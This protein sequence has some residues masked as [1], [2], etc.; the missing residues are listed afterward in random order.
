MEKCVTKEG[1]EKEIMTANSRERANREELGIR[2]WIVQCNSCRK[3]V[4]VRER[5]DGWYVECK[6]CGITYRDDEFDEGEMQ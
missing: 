6:H 4:R 3:W 2:E 5:N 1:K